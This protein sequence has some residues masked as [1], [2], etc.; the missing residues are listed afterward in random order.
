MTCGR[1]KIL[2]ITPLNP[3]CDPLDRRRNFFTTGNGNRQRG[4][5]EPPGEGETPSHRLGES[6]EPSAKRQLEVIGNG[7]TLKPSGGGRNSAANRQRGISG[8]RPGKVLSHPATGTSGPRAERSRA[9]RRRKRSGSRPG[10]RAEATGE[11]RP[12]A[13]RQWGQPRGQRRRAGPAPPGGGGDLAATGKG[14]S[15]A[16]GI[17]AAGAQGALPDRTAVERRKG[18]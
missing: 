18:R 13:T 1:P 8:S 7:K 16:L 6:S 11:G 17:R 5:P 15:L 2:K 14:Q 3:L 12:C 9:N 4:N 10:R